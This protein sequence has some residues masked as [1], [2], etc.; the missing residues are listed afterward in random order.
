MIRGAGWAWLLSGD[1]TGV[2]D[3]VNSD[4]NREREL[5]TARASCLLPFLQP[6]LSCSSQP[7]TAPQRPFFLPQSFL[8]LSNRLECPAL[9]HHNLFL[10]RLFTTFHITRSHRSFNLS[11]HCTLR[12]ISERQLFTMRGAITIAVASA[13]LASAAATPAKIEA[14][15]SSSSSSVPTVTAQGNG[16]LG[17]RPSDT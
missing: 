17:Q 6:F 10:H 13:A 11:T 3:R 16:A 7:T 14:R 9:V 12:T 1:G 8:P 15:A 4:E 2:P 5:L